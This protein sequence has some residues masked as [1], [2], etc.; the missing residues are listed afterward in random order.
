MS[1][2]LCLC[3]RSGLLRDW[4]PYII[5]YYYY[6]SPT[7]LCMR[8]CVCVCVYVCLC[9]YSRVCMYEYV[10]MYVYAC[11]CVCVCVHCAPVYGVRGCTACRLELQGS[12]G[13]EG[14]RGGLRAAGREL[15]TPVAR[16]RA[17][18][19][20]SQRHAT[21]TA[22][23]HRLH[24]GLTSIAH[25]LRGPRGSSSHLSRC[26]RCVRSLSTSHFW[27]TVTYLL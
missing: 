3:M 1:L 4:A 24:L 6:T 15:S 22:Y 11:M 27:L 19:P 26:A 10:C 14:A 21:R 25:F 8:A 7:H 2:S 13:R 17:A 23:L 12:G 18:G 5:F 16:R 20:G 9:V